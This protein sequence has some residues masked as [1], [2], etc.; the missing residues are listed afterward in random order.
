MIH[1]ALVEINL[2]SDLRCFLM[3]GLDLIG[4]RSY[5]FVPDNFKMVPKWLEEPLLVKIWRDES[6]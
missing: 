5:Y 6:R 1:S 2:D 3:G 4:Y